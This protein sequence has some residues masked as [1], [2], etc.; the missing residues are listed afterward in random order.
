MFKCASGTPLEENCREPIKFLASPT[1]K[2][3]CVYTN[4][5]TSALVRSCYSEPVDV[6]TVISNYSARAKRVSAARFETAMYTGL[7]RMLSS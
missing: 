1:D 4:T 2:T 6:V 7:K 3:D 5:L